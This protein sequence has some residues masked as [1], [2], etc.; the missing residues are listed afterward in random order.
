MKSHNVLQYKLIHPNAKPPERGYGTAAAFD[1]Y[2]AEIEKET[3]HQIW[4]ETGVAFNIPNGL[5][6]D[7]RARSSVS[8]T[9]LIQ[10]NAAGIVDPDYT[11]TI[12]FRFYKVDPTGDIYD[13]G[14]RVGQI[15]FSPYYDGE[16][17]EIDELPD[18]KRGDSGFGSTGRK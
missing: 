10:A 13:V 9:G 2:A 8:E 3:E 17:R 1:L 11:G 4:Y 6:G 15:L 7:A 12:Q 18:T 5:F 16:I 14:D